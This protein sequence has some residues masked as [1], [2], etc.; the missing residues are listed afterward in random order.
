MINYITKIVAFSFTLFIFW[1]IYIADTGGT[2]IFTKM[3]RFLPYLDKWGHF[4]LFGILTLLIN[5]AI[6]YKRVSI[7][8]K[9]VYLGTVVVFV[10]AVIE[11][12]SQGLLA[13]RSLEHLD[14]LADGLGILL[15]SYLASRVEAVR[16]D[17][18]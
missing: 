5:M 7:F 14:L 6:Q 8:N 2:I 17:L 15:F 9:T 1:I 18:G 11:E 3:I 13:T 12:L 10:F 4:I 16:S